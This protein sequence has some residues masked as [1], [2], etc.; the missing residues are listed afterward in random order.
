MVAQRKHSAARRTGAS[1]RAPASAAGTGGQGQPQQQ[2][3]PLLRRFQTADE[4]LTQDKREEAG[5]AKRPWGPPLAEMRLDIL[6]IRNLTWWGSII[7]QWTLAYKIGIWHGS[8]IW[9]PTPNSNFAYSCTGD[10]SFFNAWRT[11]SFITSSSFKSGVF[12][13]RCHC[14]VSRARSS[15]VSLS[16]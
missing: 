10:A 3:V 15:T 2:Q 6:A 7:R 4:E 5:R 11:S 8:L 12:R 13:S 1:Q 9:L 14:L 16:R